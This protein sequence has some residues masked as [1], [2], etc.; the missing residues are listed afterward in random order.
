MK[1]KIDRTKSFLGRFSKS[2]LAICLALLLIFG[3]MATSFAVVIEHA[4]L[5]ANLAAVTRSN[6][7]DLAES[8]DTTY[9][10]HYGTGNNYWSSSGIAMT[11][12]GTTW[13]ADIAFTTQYDNFVRINTTSNSINTS[14]TTSVSTS[15]TNSY[16]SVVNQISY[17][18]NVN[19]G[20]AGY[21]IELKSAPSPST[22]VRVS[23]DTSDMSTLIVSDPAGGGGGGGGGTIGTQVTDDSW[24]KILNG[25]D[26]SFYIESYVDNDHQWAHL[27]N[28]SKQTPTYTRHNMVSNHIGKAYLQI[29]KSSLSSYPRITNNVGSWDGEANSAITSTNPYPAGMHLVKGGSSNKSAVGSSTTIQNSYYDYETMSISTT[30]EATKT[31]F[32]EGSGRVY[33]MTIKYYIKSGSDYYYLDGKDYT[34]TTSAHTTSYSLSGLS[35]G[36][37]TLLTVA[38]DSEDYV[39]YIADTDDFTVSTET[40]YDVTFSVSPAGAGTISPSGS[41]QVGTTTKTDVTVTANPGYQ[42]SSWTKSNVTL[43]ND[44]A[45]GDG[46]TAKAVATAN[47]SLT[48]NFTKKSFTLSKGSETNGTF[49]LSYTTG[50]ASISSGSSVEFDSGI[51]V[52]ATP[53]TGYEVSTI[54]YTPAGGIATGASGSG[55]S[56]TFSMPAANTTVNVTFAKKNNAITSTVNPAGKATVTI[57]KSNGGANTDT[58]QIGDTLYFKASSINAAY[59]FDK[60]VVTYADGTTADVTT[61]N[62]TLTIDTTHFSGTDGS[63]SVECKLTAKPTHTVTV[64]SNNVAYGTATANVVNAYEGQTVTLTAVENTGDFKRWHV[65]SGTA[66]GVDNADTKEK[67]FTMGSGDVTIQAI[68]GAYEGGESNWYYNG[69][70]TDNTDNNYYGKQFTAAKY[71]GKEYYYYHVTGRASARGWN[72]NFTVSYGNV[73]HDDTQVYFTRPNNRN[74]DSDQYWRWSNWDTQYAYFLSSDNV[75]IKD[76][77]AMDWV[78]GTDNFHTAVPYGARYVYFKDG[79]TQHQTVRIDLSERGTY[80]GAYLWSNGEHDGD[81]WKV[82]YWEPVGAGSI[83][84]INEYFNGSSGG[85][86]T[87]TTGHSFQTYNVAYGGS[88]TTPRPNTNGDD[89]YILILNPGN[90][91]TING[92]TVTVPA[93][94]VP[95]VVWVD[96][97]PA[98]E[99][100][101]AAT[102]DIYAKDGAIR[103]DTFNRFCRLA[104][105][106]FDQ[107]YFEYTEKL[108]SGVITYN[109]IAGYNAAHAKQITF[110][111][112]PSDFGGYYEKAV[113]VPV[114]AKIKIKTTLSSNSADTG[115]F[116]DAN[117]SAVAFK[118]SHYLKA[119]SF[120]GVTYELHT[121][122]DTGVYEEIWTVSAVNTVD[123]A[124]SN[125]TKR[126][127]SVEIT[128]IYYMKDTTN[129]K[130]FY[131]DG[132]DGTVQ[133]KWGNMLSVYPYYDGKS[134]AANAFGG[135]P[136]QPML[137]WGGKYQMEIPLTVDGTGSGATVKGLT[138]HNGYWDMMH[139]DLDLVCNSHSQSYDFDDFYKIYKEKNPDSIIYEFEYRDTKDNFGE[140]YDPNNLNAFATATATAATYNG[141]GY[142]GVELLTD[143]FGRQVDVFNTLI[144]SGNL[145]TWDTTPTQGKELLIVSSGDKNTYVGEYSTVWAVYAPSSNI[146]AGSGDSANA[147]IGY[148]S[149]SMLYLKNSDRFSQYNDGTNTAKGKMSW[150]AFKNTYDHLK[151][152]Y[153]GV[154]AL[155]S[156]EKEIWNDSGDNANRSDGKWYFSNKN[157]QI[158]ADIK[159][160]YCSDTTKSGEVVMSTDRKLNDMTYWTDD[161]FSGAGLGGET[162]VGT[163]TACSAYFTNTSPYL[164]GKTASGTQFADSSKKF[165]FEAVAGGQYLFVNW[166]RYSNGKYYEIT[167]K[168]LGESPMSANDTYIARFVKADV[169]T[170]KISHVIEQ[171]ATY[172]GTG[173][174]SVTVTVTNG[175]TVVFTE[176][177]TDGTPIDISRYMNTKYS[178]YKVDISLSSTPDEDCT[179]ANISQGSG[180]AKYNPAANSASTTVA[181]F[182]IND[183]LEVAA[184]KVSTLRYVTHLNTTIFTYNYNITYTYPSRFWGNQSYTVSGTLN[185]GRAEDM[186]NITGKKGTAQLTTDFIINKTPYEKNFRQKINW[187]YTYA[188]VGTAAAMTN[189]SALSAGTTYNIT[190]TVQAASEVDDRVKADFVLPYPYKDRANGYAAEPIN[191]YN[192]SDEV[193][194][195]EYI[196]DEAQEAVTIEGQAY[197]LFFTDGQDHEILDYESSAGLPLMEAAPYV[198]KD[199]AARYVQVENLRYYTGYSFTVGGT[200]YW[201]SEVPDG[202]TGTAVTAETTCTWNGNSYTWAVLDATNNCVYSFAQNGANGQYTIR[203]LV[204]ELDGFYIDQTAE[205]CKKYFTR[206]DIYDTAGNYIAS[207]VNRRFAYTGYGNY[208]VRAIYESDSPNAAAE[209][210]VNTAPTITYLGDTRNQWNNNGK[211]SYE[212]NVSAADKL[213]HDFA[214]SFDYYDGIIR[215][216]D[217]AAK[218]GKDIKIGMLIEQIETLDTDGAGNKIT[219]LSYYADKYKSGAKAFNATAL[220]SALESGTNPK[221]AVGHNVANSKI[222][223]NVSGWGTPFSETSGNIGTGSSVKVIDNMNRLQWYYTFNN[224]K[225]NGEIGSGNNANFIYRASAYIIVDGTAT[226]SSTPVYFTLYDSASR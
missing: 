147:L 188:A 75:M 181:Q 98:P 170:L 106:T 121:A 32:D 5:G 226:L 130:T 148:I 168:E 173:T 39:R 209:D 203:K 91:Y 108:D 89:Y 6:D 47:G 83:G 105:T 146:P 164:R 21:K 36:S 125:L 94:D 142:N 141:S 126:G 93:G 139:R 90:T 210:P 100:E 195:Q 55:N 206:W 19:S 65:L 166:V 127:N 145:S 61:N 219:D 48:A 179:F 86:Y 13:Y 135:Y 16:S 29:A 102:V 215:D 151:T 43:S 171:N 191:A 40:K 153:T 80:L 162:N 176:T 157:D 129:V 95:K 177:K 18:N 193:V 214:I 133:G 180:I 1:Q 218:G 8:G 82:S 46:R 24:L 197:H 198:W 45:S 64:I 31:A 211:G 38:V 169:G 131:I 217:N 10:Y 165:T 59:T 4:D 78:S 114:G 57:S 85:I 136:G 187:N 3:T 175:S 67:T 79:N 138:L 51:T 122:N 113:N 62:G 7:M 22:T 41:N 224:T 225:T 52:T 69:Y 212:Y 221:T 194:S 132:Y 156:F 58:Y 54:T 28:T 116:T 161:T 208:V 96:E 119:Y 117:G 87:N 160:Q 140:G 120:N 118:N 74:D 183:A 99:V 50:G 9:Y 66:A 73:K 34:A 77:T 109:S 205:S 182:T 213:M 172:T 223:A 192:R 216:T 12:S 154:P 26:V 143:Y 111:T 178:A 53:D 101:E 196:Y 11:Q 155:I 134:N 115:S 110:T 68:F 2:S 107:T 70:T 76:W 167:E 84:T 222:G 137:R 186:T 124:G 189:S 42:F 71:D 200:K 185:G 202:E 35:A 60:F 158:S 174:P 30:S 150:A 97:I 204:D 23:F 33:N 128:P 14:N 104:D 37:Y 207:N 63:I 220:K 20:Y 56:R 184:T 49:A 149:P 163:T 152:Y 17:N 72:Q 159:I 15:Y 92:D 112:A 103:D 27:T 25:T 190:A 44:T 123:N 88:H 199:P 144:P 81:N 201:Y